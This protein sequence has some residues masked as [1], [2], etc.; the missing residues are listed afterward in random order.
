MD[1]LP[2]LTY[3]PDS[4]F[5]ECRG[6]VW[7]RCGSKPPKKPW[8]VAV[9]PRGFSCLESVNF[10]HIY[11]PCL[12]TCSPKSVVGV[13]K[14]RWCSCVCQVSQVKMR[15]KPRTRFVGVMLFLDAL[16]FTIMIFTLNSFFIYMT[17]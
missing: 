11:I 3:G 8:R 2:G 14:L 13:Y 7:W 1:S 10:V 5:R 9:A 6:A 12:N 4:K 16:D 17:V 15:E